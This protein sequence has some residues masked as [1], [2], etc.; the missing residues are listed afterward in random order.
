MEV[1][2][3]QPSKYQGVNKLSPETIVIKDHLELLWCTAIIG[4]YRGEGWYATCV[5]D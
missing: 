1:L 5:W 2:T 3:T 4:S